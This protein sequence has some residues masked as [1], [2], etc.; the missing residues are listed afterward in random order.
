MLTLLV[1]HWSGKEERYGG[2]F[3]ALCDH[4]DPLHRLQSDGKLFWD[5][6]ISARAFENPTFGY[7]TRNSRKEKL[8]AAGHKDMV[9]QV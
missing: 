5:S 6:R 3:P 1:V 9:S 2:E 4:L 7:A 8:N